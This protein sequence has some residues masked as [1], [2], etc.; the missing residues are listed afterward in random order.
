MLSAL[1]FFIILLYFQQI[2][3]NFSPPQIRLDS[4]ITE[5]KQWFPQKLTDS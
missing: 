4:S 5:K 1:L 3:T 2:L